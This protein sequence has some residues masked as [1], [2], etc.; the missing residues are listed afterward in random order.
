MRE[1]IKKQTAE[2]IKEII[3]MKDLTQVEAGKILN[4]SQ[5][6]VSLILSGKLKGFTLGKL[7]IF[8]TLLDCDI[9]I[10]SSRCENEKGNITIKKDF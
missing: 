10:R 9:F 7:L 5:S 6:K 4:I 1:D 2:I 8:L 3:K